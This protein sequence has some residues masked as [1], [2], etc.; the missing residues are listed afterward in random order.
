MERFSTQRIAWVEG[1]LMEPQHFQQQ[2]RFFEHRINQRVDALEPFH[3]GFSQIEINHALLEQGKFA[4]TRARGIFPDGTPFSLPDDA[5]L[6][7]PLVVDETSRGKSICLVVM[8]D[9]PGV[10][11]MDLNRQSEKSRFNTTDADIADS[12]LGV[13]SEGSPR[14]ITLELGRLNCRLLLQEEVSSAESSLAIAM[15]TDRQH[16]GRVQIAEEILPPLLD[17]HASRWLM[18]ATTELL[19]LITQRLENVSRADVPAAVGGLSELLEL[20]LLQLLSE[21]QLR[22]SHLLDSPQT[23]PEKLYQTL[24]GLLGRLS[25]IPDGEKAWSR[26]DLH[27]QHP[28]PHRCFFPLMQAI[29]RALSLV[30]EAPAVALNFSERGDNILVCQNDGQLRLEKVVFAVSS[31]LPG[32]ILRSYF[33]AQVKLGPVEKIVHLIDL[34][35]PGARIMPMSTP[36]RHVPWYPNSVYFETDTADPLYREMMAGPAMALSIVGD[37]PELRID[38][39]GL[40]QGRIG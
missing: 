32:D 40:R 36:P 26:S 14:T 20:L 11:L 7:L 4:L 24:L 16:D 31:A 37:F 12:N 1:M 2:E 27:Y 25:I 8:M 17:V 28:A 10:P 13:S 39:W 9:L 3:W 15:I 21:Y 35:L 29:R 22:F 6:P 18:A 23:H 5:P 34:Q 30:I 33:P 38:S 19:G